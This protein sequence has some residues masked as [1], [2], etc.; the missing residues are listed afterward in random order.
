MVDSPDPMN[1]RVTATQADTRA[2][3]LRTTLRHCDLTI[4]TAFLVDEALALPACCP[5]YGAIDG[6]RLRLREGA[7][8]R[9]ADGRWGDE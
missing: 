9:P 4:S 6:F 2:N 1:R 8:E 7:E 3:V 5:C